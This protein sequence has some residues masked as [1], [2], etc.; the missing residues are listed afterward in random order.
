MISNL[1]SQE[2]LIQP[3][4]D[5]IHTRYMNEYLSHV[6]RNVL[7][8]YLVEI[9]TAISD[10]RGRP[11]DSI[12]QDPSPWMPRSAGSRTSLVTKQVS[13]SRT[14]PKV[15][16]ERSKLSTFPTTDALSSQGSIVDFE[17][18]SSSAK[19]ASW[20][21]NLGLCGSVVRRKGYKTQSISVSIRYRPPAV[22]NRRSFIVLVDFA[23]RFTSDLWKISTLH[24]NLMP[25]NIIPANATI[26]QACKYGYL[27]QARKLFRAKMA[28]TY[29]IT[30]TN[31]SLLYVGNA[32]SGINTLDTL[33]L[34][35]Q[36]AI[37]GGH[38]E[39]VR[40]LLDEGAD[41]NQTFGQNQTY[42]EILVDPPTYLY[43]FG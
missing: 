34:V 6:P 35:C 18:Q 15:T 10:L 40:L 33:I 30:S 5:Q 42:V 21:W 4:L 37:E 20:L 1:I 24:F 38:L 17:W 2:A 12:N 16:E 19:L 26:I 29:D 43:Y 8:N 13:R 3:L 32:G 39:L 41:V 36:F 27:E 7:H 11:L 28:S 14:I 23:L 25:L 31:Y 9:E 22:W